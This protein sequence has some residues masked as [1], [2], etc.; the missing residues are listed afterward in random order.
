[1]TRLGILEQVPVFR[2]SSAPTAAR[3]A[4][5]LGISA[6]EMGL[7]RYW[8][9][10]HHDDPSRGCAAPEVLTALVAARTERIRV[11][12]GCVNLPAT[13]PSR[14]AEQ[15]SLLG[16]VAPGRVDL[17]LGRGA[18]PPRAVGDGADTFPADVLEV[19]RRLRAG[20][21]AEPPQPW[22]MGSGERGALVAAR[23]GL[24]FAFAQFAHDRVRAD[25]TGLYREQFLPGPWCAEPTV[26]VAA[27]ISCA[28]TAATAQRQ[29]L[30]VWLPV[31]RHPSGDRV[32]PHPT[33]PSAADLRSQTAESLDPGL[34][35]QLDANPYLT[36][37]GTPD[38]V[39]AVLADLVDQHH[40]TELVM[41]TTCP[42][43]NERIR[44][45]ALAATA[46]RAV[47]MPR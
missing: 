37:T 29:A 20:A 15:W 41:T 26:A 38:A 40:A 32:W 22:L 47:M 4:V 31:L 25:I 2:G 6:E 39:A 9:A 45:F 44:T 36:I 8:I 34:R 27:R 14:V 16:A 21:D 1:M 13:T 7:F 18:Q 5:S 12:A 24:P 43:L 46:F 19:L 23:L 17:G 28:E 3:E 35:A 10:E 33:Y 42:D 30:A 11:G